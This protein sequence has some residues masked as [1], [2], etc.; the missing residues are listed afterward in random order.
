MDIDQIF[1]KSP[2]KLA[3]LRQ[4]SLLARY[5]S[6]LNFPPHG[7]KAS[8]EPEEVF[9]DAQSDQGYKMEV[10]IKRRKFFFFY[11]LAI[12]LFFILV[13]MAGWL[14]II[15]GGAYLSQAEKNRVRTI[16][17]FS[18]RGI[19][20]DRVGE[21]LI[22]NVSTFDLVAIPAYLPKEENGRE[23]VFRELGDVLG[24]D[25]EMLEAA[26]MGVQPFSFN[27]V[28]L[29]GGIERE[30]ALFLETELKNLPGVEIESNLQREYVFPFVFS[31]IIGYVG[32]MTE[33]DLGGRPDYFSTETI[34]KSGLELEYENV[35]RTL[36]GK[37]EVEVDA[38]G[39]IGQTLRVVD[40]GD[41][42]GLVLSIDADLQNFIYNRLGDA[43][44]QLR[45]S[46]AV[47]VA[48]NP[49]NGHILALVTIPSFDNNL[50]SQGISQEKYGQLLS[51]PL[52]PLFNRA[53]S[54][55]Y[56]PGSTI[57]PFVGAAALEEGVVTPKTIINDVGPLVLGGWTF[58][59]WK[60]HGLVD[61][62][63]AI[64]ESCNI[65]FYTVGGGYGD[66]KGLGVDRL[67]KYLKL[68]GFGSLTGIDLPNEK[69][70]FIPS[71][72]WK[73]ETKGESWY[74]GDTYH[75]SI[76][77]GDV[78]VTPLQMSVLTAAIANG[79]TVWRP[80]IVDKIIDSEKNVIEE[81]KPQGRKIDFV[82]AQNLDITGFI[83]KEN[84]DITGF[85]SKE[86]LDITGFI[87]KENLDIIRSAMRQTVT[88]G[89]A[90]YLKTLSVAAAGKT[91]TAQTTVD[92]KNNAWFTVFAPF[93]SPEIELTILIEEG[94]E[95][96]TSAVP[97]ARDI[98]QWYFNR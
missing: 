9:L 74:I 66:F 81:I 98:L 51:N 53:V 38:Y 52:Q 56:A 61:I 4:K 83:S 85:I 19:I 72:E 40:P 24:E 88:S 1:E 33:V 41:A 78:T 25:P 39:T 79:G 48:L 21:Q 11:V 43:L 93:D 44:K 30:K 84:L 46:R 86:N 26:M 37:K 90:Q 73:K 92:K 16:P 27:P 17:I 80:Y 57:K 7:L 35:L 65:Y 6:F 42:R 23:E 89:S 20:Y 91:G 12:I 60:T 28:L 69:T 63:R 10:P 3:G 59:D 45:V 13:G 82:S 77:Q 55:Q 49:Q 18:P 68:F 87:S 34:G 64:A 47:A 71:A 50:M 31:H 15:K 54:G 62:Y 14:Q 58:P 70:G 96:S 94:V 8:L 32:K 22:Y 76:G 97:V 2:R 36:P 95:G 5:F 67:E 29:K 75:M